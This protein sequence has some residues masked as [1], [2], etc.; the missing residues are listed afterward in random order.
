MK[1]LATLCAAAILFTAPVFAQQPS[2]RLTFDVAVV[3]PSQPGQLNGGIK[4]FPG[5]FGYTASN[6]NVRLMIALMYG[7]SVHQVTGGPEWLDSDRY[8]VEA[9][10]DRPYGRDDLHTL[11]QHLL[12]DRFHLTMRKETVEGPVYVLTLDGAAQKMKRNDSPEDFHIPMTF[13]PNGSSIGA[14]VPMSYLAWWL[15][16]Q[17][18]QE[19]RPVIDRTGLPGYYDFTLSFAP[20]RPPGAENPPEEQR[21]SLFTA[22]REQLGLKLT[23][24]KGPITHYVITHVE[25]PSA[26]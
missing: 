10:S 7:V 4:P 12:E 6:V 13:A 3:R 11:F 17:L 26:N 25:K 22:L 21:P 18:Q 16:Q 2:L 1:R 14:R 15:G 8:D 9:K 19:N 23:P 20:I 5:G 24:D